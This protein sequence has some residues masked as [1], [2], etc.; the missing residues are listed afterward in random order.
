MSKVSL[1]QLKN[2]LLQGLSRYIERFKDQ[3]IYI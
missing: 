2:G 1:R 3:N